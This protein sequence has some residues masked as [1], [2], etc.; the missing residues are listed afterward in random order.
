[1]S[2][3]LN[4]RLGINALLWSLAQIGAPYSGNLSS[5]AGIAALCQHIRQHK[6]ELTRLGTLET[7]ADVREQEAR[8]LLCKK[9]IGSNLLEFARHVLGQRQAAVPLLRGY[10]QG[11]TS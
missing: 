2:S 5:S 1:M 8:A 9:G 3:Y 11:D 10:D 4:A 7:I 6:A